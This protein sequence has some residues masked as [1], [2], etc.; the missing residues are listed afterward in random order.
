ML[1]LNCPN[2]FHEKFYSDSTNQVFQSIPI[3]KKKT[4][5]F[6]D[7]EDNKFEEEI[8]KEDNSNSLKLSKKKSSESK[9]SIKKKKT[10][11]HRV[12]KPNKIKK[13]KNLINIKKKNNNY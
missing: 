9:N 1:V 10:N 13:N 4:S 6:D 5:F 2:D 3:F 8:N 11:A 12:N 7:N